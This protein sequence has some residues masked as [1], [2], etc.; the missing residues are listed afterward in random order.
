MIVKLFLIENRLKILKSTL[1]QILAL[2]MVL[3]T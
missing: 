2:E 3:E 1:K